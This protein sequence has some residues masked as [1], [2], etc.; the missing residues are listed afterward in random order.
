MGIFDGIGKVI[1]GGVELVK[2]AV[3]VPVD[4]A[5]TAGKL[6]WNAASTPLDIAKDTVVGAGKTGLGVLT[7]NGDMARDGLKQATVGNVENVVDHV[8]INPLKIVS[9]GLNDQW[10]N[11]TGKRISLP[12]AAPA[13]ASGGYPGATAFPGAM[14]GAVPGAPGPGGYGMPPGAGAPMPPQSQG[15]IA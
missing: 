5:V 4:A 12:Q 13:A 8:A 15:W 14:P 7:L 10:E 11:L 2:S 1:G 6:A 9:D 3:E